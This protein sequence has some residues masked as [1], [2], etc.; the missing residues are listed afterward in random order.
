MKFST[1]ESALEDVKAGKPLVIVDDP[2]RE[3]EGD[4]YVAAEKITP[5]GIR[6]MRLHATGR[7][8]VP[9]L[10]DRLRY[11]ELPL[12]VPDSYSDSRRCRFTLT[13]DYKHIRDGGV[14]DYDRALTIKKLIDTTSSKDDFYRPGHIDPLM[15]EHNG[16]SS[17]RGHTEAAIDLAR[18]SNLYPAGVICEVVRRNGEMA[19]GESLE[20]FAK[21]FDLKVITIADIVR[22]RNL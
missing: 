19:R 9:L 5:S 12:M 13:V 14:S 7:I 4:V 11:L 17:R 2:E 16:V 22:Y 3:N 10:S 1:I 15:A 8:C 21:R 18:L 6:F 20:R